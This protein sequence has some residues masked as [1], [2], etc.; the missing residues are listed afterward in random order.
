[1]VPLNWCCLQS[2]RVNE[3]AGA[4]AIAIIVNPGSLVMSGNVY[5]NN[6]AGLGPG[7]VLLSYG[8][9]PYDL[10]NDVFVLSTSLLHYVKITIQ[11][12]LTSASMAAL[13]VPFIHCVSRECMTACCQAFVKM[14][15]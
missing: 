2:N 6:S 12:S 15:V 9:G 13:C 1:M 5:Y 8:T 11:P 14:R 4:I 3:S 10:S 7:A